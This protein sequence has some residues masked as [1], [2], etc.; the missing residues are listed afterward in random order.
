MKRTICFFWIHFPSSQIWTRLYGRVYITQLLCDHGQ[1]PWL[2]GTLVFLAMKWDYHC[3]LQ[4]TSTANWPELVGAGSGQG[5]GQFLCP[6]RHSIRTA[7]SEPAWRLVVKKE[8]ALTLGPESPEGG[9]QLHCD[10]IS[11][12]A[13]RIPA[14]WKRTAQTLCSAPPE[15]YLGAG[16]AVTLTFR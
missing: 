12:I 11:A 4:R 8:Q 2:L 16:V 7:P 15:G 14:G 1:A 9:R 10:E 3:P 6:L 13:A 5:L